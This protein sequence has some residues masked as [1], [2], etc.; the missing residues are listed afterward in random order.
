MAAPTSPATR[1][2]FVNIGLT[3]GYCKAAFSRTTTSTRAPGCA[4]KISVATR[5]D[6][7]GPCGSPDDGFLIQAAGHHRRETGFVIS[8]GTLYLGGLRLTLET[9]EEYGL[10]KDWLQQSDVTPA[11]TAPAAG[12]SISFTSKPGGKPPPGWKNSRLLEAGLDAETSARVRTMRRV[13]CE[14]RQHRRGGL[15]EPA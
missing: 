12:G 9:D 1:P 6:V 4:K 14:D 3:C 7:I 2:I 10:Q 11:L 5:V 13:L 15:P 8:A